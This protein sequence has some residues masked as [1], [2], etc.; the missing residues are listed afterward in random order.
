MKLIREAAGDAH[1]GKHHLFRI[2]G[3]EK[4]CDRIEEIEKLLGEC[5]TG[6]TVFSEYHQKM[7][8]ETYY[9]GY[10]DWCAG[11]RELGNGSGWLVDIDSVEEFKKNWIRI[12]KLVK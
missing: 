9:H 3:T 1:K 2:V 12:K 8:P 6:R 7:V 10:N 5:L 11:E 4:D